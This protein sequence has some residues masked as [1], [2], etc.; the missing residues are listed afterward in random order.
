MATASPANEQTLRSFD[1]ETHTDHATSVHATLIVTDTVHITPTAGTK[2][3]S[4]LHAS[5]AK[6]MLWPSAHISAPFR[7]SSCSSEVER[8]LVCL[9]RIAVIFYVNVLAAASPRGFTP[10]HMAPA[11]FVRQ[12]LKSEAKSC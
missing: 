6:N 2:G 11:S 3:V 1:N 8:A 12:R 4:N 7:P 5:I 10:I 9:T